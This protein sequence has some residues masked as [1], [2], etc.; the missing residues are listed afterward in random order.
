MEIIPKKSVPEDIDDINLSE[1]LSKLFPKIDQV[2][3]EKKEDEKRE[4]DMEHLT[5]ILS[6]IGDKPFQF[7]FS[8]GGK[9]KKFHDT[10]RSYGLSTD[11]LEFLDFLQ[12]DICKKNINIKQ[13][14]NTC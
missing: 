8:T 1:Q 14:K 3:D 6:K 4:M 7:E 13:A 5:E 12:S 2:L 11:N 10:M 9:N